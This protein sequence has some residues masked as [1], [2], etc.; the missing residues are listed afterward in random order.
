[1]TAAM[2]GAI[3]FSTDDGWIP[4]FVK[5]GENG[6]V[7]PKA[8]YANMNTHQQDEYDLNKAYE[9]LEN[10]IIPMYYENKDAWR[11]IVKNGMKDVRYEF[12][13]NRM[14]HEYYE[15]MYKK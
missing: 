1:M 2:N 5:H 7:I 11:Q 10:E 9:I 4:E 6:F 14:A 15:I 12:D 13:S 3:N 8:D